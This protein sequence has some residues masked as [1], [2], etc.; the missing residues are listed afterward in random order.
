MTLSRWIGWF[1]ASLFLVF[2]IS[3][4]ARCDASGNVRF[5]VVGDVHLA[6][7]SENDG[8]KALADSERILGLVIETLNTIPHLDFVVFNGDLVEVPTEENA[9]R[10]ASMLS[11]LSVPYYLTL[12]NHDVPHGVGADQ[13]ARPQLSKA[14][15]VRILLDRGLADEGC[16]R[17]SATPVAGLRIIGLD[18][19]VPGSWGGRITANALRWLE[20][21]LEGH[22]GEMTILFLH[23]GVIQ[24]WDGMN[25]DEGFFVQNRDQLQA[26]C[27][28][29]PDVKCVV[30]SHFHAGGGRVYRGIRYFA[31][32]S[33]VSYPCEFA[34]FTVTSE[35]VEMA[36][37]PIPDG[38]VIDTARRLLGGDLLWRGFFP[39]GDAG[40]RE[41]ERFFNGQKLIRFPVGLP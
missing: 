25:L 16:S 13:P 15:V 1:L 28:R 2:P 36:R 20:L 40:G 9:R 19:S 31:T 21:E 33:V 6:L 3:L 39:P 11:G 22:S 41:M 35:A 32:P 17:W 38:R 18:S 24:I 30:S 29:H 14:D 27:E 5:A 34:L 12:G 4:T 10:F 26:L 8:M 37:V 23:H 7:N